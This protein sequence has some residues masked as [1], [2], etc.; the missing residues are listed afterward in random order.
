MTAS[1]TMLEVSFREEK[2]H[3]YSYENAADSNCSI[4]FVHGFASDHSEWDTAASLFPSTIA[5]YSMNL[6]GFGGSPF[7]SSGFSLEYLKHSICES[8]DHM[9]GKKKILCGYSMGAR[10]SLTAVLETKCRPDF[11]ILESGTAGISDSMIRTARIKDDSILAER[12]ES[13]SRS[14]FEELWGGREMFRSQK[15]LDEQVL[16][17]L[18]ERRKN[19][20]PEIL[21]EYLRTFGTGVMENLWEKLPELSIPTLLISG[22]EDEKFT[23]IA[24][25]MNKLIARSEHFIVP[26]AGHNTHLEEPEYFVN[27]LLKKIL[28]H[29]LN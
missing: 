11:L 24:M 23:A 16:F 5:C 1:G 9:P 13:L 29:K 10:L 18:S 8:F 4:L 6:P 2:L 28:S 7:P 14:D 25:E 12:I 26:N 17:R 3:I 15:S 27:L 21:A 19:T 22:S 20:A